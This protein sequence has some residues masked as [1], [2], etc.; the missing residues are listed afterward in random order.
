MHGLGDSARVPLQTCLLWFPGKAWCK[1][2]SANGK[3]LE[4]SLPIHHPVS[5]YKQLL[6]LAC[7]SLLSWDLQTVLGTFLTEF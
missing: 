3:L 1:R 6:S 7:G 5:N 4:S 2:L